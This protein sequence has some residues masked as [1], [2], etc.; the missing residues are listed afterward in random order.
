[1]AHI[2]ETGSTTTASPPPRRFFRPRFSLAALFGVMTL[3]CVGVWYWYQWPYEVEHLTY[4][5]GP[6]PRKVVEREVE[7]V[8]NV[9]SRDQKT[10]RHG[11]WVVY[12]GKGQK[13]QEGNY[14][15]G[16]KH[17]VFVRYDK[18]GK[19]E[20]EDHY[21][22]GILHG[23]SRRWWHGRLVEETFYDRGV[24]HGRNHSRSWNGDIA[25]LQ[26][27]HGRLEGPY[28]LSQPVV[29]GEFRGGKPDGEW[30]YFTGYWFD[31]RSPAGLTAEWQDGVPTG[32]WELV[33][34]GFSPDATIGI[35]MQF[36][37]GRL[38]KVEPDVLEPRLAELLA[39]GEIHD[40]KLI[41]A[42]FSVTEV[43]V[44]GLPFRDV[45][46]ILA[47]PSEAQVVLSQAALEL[48]PESVPDYESFPFRGGRVPTNPL[49]PF[50]PGKTELLQLPITCGFESLPLIA[51]LRKIL[52]PLGLVCEYR[53]GVLRITTPDE[54]AR[55]DMTGVTTIVPPRGSRLEAAWQRPADLTFTETPLS[56]ALQL[57]ESTADV[58]FDISRLP[59][60][61]QSIPT[62]RNIRGLPLKHSLGCLLDGFPLCASLDGETIVVELQDGHPLAEPI[63]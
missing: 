20:Q 4:D 34:L 11:P 9:W 8:R 43:N 47:R 32:T 1:M 58:R 33:D 31:E 14:R 17:G 37:G 3:A 63:P 41:R 13:K 35:T 39:Q 53:Y 21:A 57:L 10:V 29:E 59:A 54:A 52:E 36:N 28:L 5:S 44:I 7:T 50:V 25:E 16:A 55:G 42:L 6:E 40:P 23:A 15:N 26:Y 12:G 56:D 60:K 2:P 49:D 61:Y 46:E 22:S 18:K 27:E 51:V 62:T 19:K 38:V 30:T 45:V 24:L 48:R